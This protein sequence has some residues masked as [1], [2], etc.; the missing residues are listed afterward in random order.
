MTFLAFNSAIAKVCF[1]RHAARHSVGSCHAISPWFWCK[2]NRTIRY[3]R[4]P[5]MLRF[6]SARLDLRSFCEYLAGRVYSTEGQSKGAYSGCVLMIL[7]A[8]N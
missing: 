3:R 8:Q 7:H 4:R 5:L 1:L 6:A 2:T